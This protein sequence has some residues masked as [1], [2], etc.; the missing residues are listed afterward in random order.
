MA[1]PRRELARTE[2]SSREAA[3]RSSDPPAFLLSSGASLQV[4]GP[5][6]FFTLGFGRCFFGRIRADEPLQARDSLGQ[7]RMTRFRLLLAQVAPVLR[8]GESRRFR[9]GRRIALSF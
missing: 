4:E 3:N 2:L 8:V 7:R 5:R 1:P 6:N 9:F